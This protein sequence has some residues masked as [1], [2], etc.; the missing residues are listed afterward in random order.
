MV[1]ILVIVSTFL[2]Q[3]IF[4][5]SD[6]ISRF[7]IL[8]IHMIDRRHEKSEKDIKKDIKR[9][10]IDHLPKDFISK[11]KFDPGYGYFCALYE[12][13]PFRVHW[14]CSE[15]HGCSVAF[16][17]I[18]VRKK[19]HETKETFFMWEDFEISCEEKMKHFECQIIRSFDHI[20]KQFSKRY[21][22]IRIGHTSRTEIEAI[23]GRPEFD[24]GLRLIYVKNRDLKREE[25][26]HKDD[27]NPRKGIF[28]G[29]TLSFFFKHDRLRG[30]AMASG[31][32]EC[33]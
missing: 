27:V 12:K 22:S 23:F 30:A 4:E 25:E 33:L 24:N 21:P 26:C 32:S 6:D 3:Y 20:M 29:D 8:G 14:E 2:V 31:D 10:L 13:E 16:A 11:N 17:K 19:C 7:D 15:M 1:L 28:Y 5:Q 18:D 9:Y